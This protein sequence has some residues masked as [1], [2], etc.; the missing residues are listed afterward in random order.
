MKKFLGYVL[1]VAVV[2]AAVHFCSLAWAQPAAQPPAPPAAPAQTRVAFIN[3]AK[4]FQDYEKAKV[5]HEEIKRIA[6]PKRKEHEKLVAEVKAW[7]EFMQKPENAEKFTTGSPKYDVQLKAQYEQGIINNKRKLEDLNKEMT[8]LLEEKH[9]QQYLQLY[10]EMS[11]VV[12]DHAGKN[13]FQVVLAYVEPT[14][15]DPFDIVNIMRKVQGM[16]MGGSITSLYTAPGI[17]IT[18]PILD[19]LNAWHRSAQPLSKQ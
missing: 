13:N 2:G 18:V 12:Q 11:A 9:K 1:G 10:K 7:T 5:F 4:I 15:R 3:V 6:E 19:A 16:D 17:D 14:T 8:G